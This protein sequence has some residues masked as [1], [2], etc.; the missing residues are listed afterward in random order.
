MFAVIKTLKPC[1]IRKVFFRIQSIMV[2]EQSRMTQIAGSYLH[3]LTKFTGSSVVLLYFH[4]GT[5]CIQD[6]AFC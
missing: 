5:T 1:Q 4:A 6:R 3:G 2:Q